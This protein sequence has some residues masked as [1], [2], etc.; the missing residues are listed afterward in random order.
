MPVLWS[1]M[2]DW[3]TQVVVEYHS[4]DH[5]ATI[6]KHIDWNNIHVCKQHCFGKHQLAFCHDQQSSSPFE[7]L[8]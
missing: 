4:I 1:A 6:G 3:L 5:T 8:Y 7:Y 2:Y